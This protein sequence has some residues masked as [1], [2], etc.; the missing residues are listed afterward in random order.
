ML[1]KFVRPLARPPPHLFF[2][3]QLCRTNRFYDAKFL[4]VFCG[5]LPFFPVLWLKQ[6][7]AGQMCHTIINSIIPPR[8]CSLADQT[9]VHAAEYFRTLWLFVTWRINRWFPRMILLLTT[10][11]L[12]TLIFAKQTKSKNPAVCSTSQLMMKQDRCYSNSTQFFF[13]VFLQSGK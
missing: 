8:F 7:L 12:C 9:R 10:Q 11:A 13:E 2:F 1:L 3:F 6:G 5:L 4:P